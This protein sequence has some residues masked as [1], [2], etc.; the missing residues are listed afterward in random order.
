MISTIDEPHGVF[1]CRSSTLTILAS[2]GPFRGLLATVLG[3]RAV[4][5]INDP[6]GA[7]KCM[8]SIETVWAN[9]EQFP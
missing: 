9:S 5:M 6:R 7:F 8:S 3:P 2:S 4:S 1:T